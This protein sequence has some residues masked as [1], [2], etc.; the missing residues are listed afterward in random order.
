MSPQLRPDGIETPTRGSS[1]RPWAGSAGRATA[2][3]RPR[4]PGTNP[5]G[6]AG[7]SG[8]RGSSGVSPAQRRTLDGGPWLSIPNRRGP[9]GSQGHAGSR[10]FGS[11]P[12]VAG[13]GRCVHSRGWQAPA[14][15]LGLQEV[16]GARDGPRLP[17]ISFHGLR[18]SHATLLGAGV[19]LKL[20]S[21]RLGHGSVRIT[22]DTYQH[23]ERAMDEDAAARAAALVLG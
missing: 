9:P 22:A 21:E 17:V 11:R 3:D 18:H 15:G 14:S 23:V 4:P 16:L 10:A 19:D 12:G 2:L 8:G 13:L 1:G 20:A 6:R 7:S 5:Q